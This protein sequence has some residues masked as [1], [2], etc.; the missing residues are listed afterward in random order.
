[1]EDNCERHESLAAL[2]QAIIDRRAILF[3]GAGVSMQVGLPSWQALTEYMVDELELDRD[4]LSK[5]DVHY[6]T[7]A[8]YYR[9]RGG[10]MDLLG[11]WLRDNWSICQEQVAGSA[12]HELLVSLDFPV[13]YTTN[14]D[15]NLEAA[16]EHHG[17]PYAKITNARDLTEVSEG[18]TQ[19]IKF[20]GDLDDPASLVLAES[21]HFERLSFET[22]LDVRF[23]A[24]ALGKTVLFIGYSMSDMNIR[25]LLYRLWQTWQRSGFAEDRPP[26]FIFMPRGNEVQEAV[27]RH[28]GISVLRDETEDPGLALIDFLRRL[29]AEVALLRRASPELRAAPGWPGET[30]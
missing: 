9:L 25:L 7:V 8:E 12:A 3:V 14:Y 22:P 28:W 13:I 5:P 30:Y 2:A 15:R 19:I 26:S 24:D 29:A 20:H 18:V 17:K 1:M 11:H 23:R 4:L 21:D 6:Q 10:N 16:F 27:L